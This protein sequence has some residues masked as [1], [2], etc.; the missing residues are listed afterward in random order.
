M[1]RRSEEQV[2]PTVR[3]PRHRHF[4]GFFT[5]PVQAPTQGNIGFENSDTYYSRDFIFARDTCCKCSRDFIFAICHILFYNLYIRNYWRGLYFSRFHLL[6]KLCENKVLAYKRCFTVIRLY[7]RSLLENFFKMFILLA[8][9][10]LS[11][12]VINSL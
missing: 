4:I 2:G 8:K 1:C 5:V 3:L 11:F 9:Q 7:P 10:R 6:A 12:N